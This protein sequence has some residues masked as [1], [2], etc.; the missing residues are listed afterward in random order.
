MEQIKNMKTFFTSDLHYSH[1]NVIKY[2]NRPFKDVTEMNETLI[3]N[4]NSVVTQTD[5]VFLLGDVSFTSK[6][7]TKIFLHQ[8]NGKIH[9]ILGNHDQ[10]NKMEYMERFEWIKDY[11]KLKKDGFIMCLFH[12]PILNWDQKHYGSFSLNGHSHGSIPV[13]YNTRRIDIGVDTKLSN[14]FP[15]SWDK[16]KEEFKKYSMPTYDHHNNKLRD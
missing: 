1:S 8:L 11:Y 13:D 7:I 3:K 12:Y 15:I 9:L 16:L 5:E 2:S 6:E 14:Y 10:R 4:W